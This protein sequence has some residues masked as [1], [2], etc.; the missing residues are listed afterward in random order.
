MIERIDPALPVSES[1]R[2]RTDALYGED[3]YRE[4]LHRGH[5]FRDNRRKHEMRWQAVLR[6]MR[7]ASTDVVLDL[8]CAAGE[9][10]VRIA[11]LVRQVTGID[12]SPA[13][14]ALAR[15]RADGVPNAT[16]VEA[17][18]TALRNVADTTVDKIMAI[19]FVEHIPD[20]D[21][22][23]MLDASW[24]VLRS[25]GRVAIYTPC[26]THYIERM[27]AHGVILQQI[28]GHIAVRTPKHCERLFAQRHW[29]IADRF[30]LPSTYPLFGLLDRLLAPLPGIGGLFRFRYCI[31]LEK[32]AAP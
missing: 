27:K 10:A 32:P 31:V 7:P 12:S 25:A 9:H 29:I 17:D 3:Y 15:E 11:P 2:S 14:I 26:R 21:L 30:F 18:A 8:G 6:M 19:D 1:P 20:A 16:F 4:Q 23:R 5:W 24:R 13:A 22:S 28:P